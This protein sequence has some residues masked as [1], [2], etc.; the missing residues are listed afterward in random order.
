VYS[1]SETCGRPQ[2]LLYWYLDIYIHTHTHTHTHIHTHT[3]TADMYTHTRT[4]GKSM[5]LKV[6]VS[7]SQQV[8]KS[9]N[10]QLN[11]TLMAAISNMR[12]ITIDITCVYICVYIYIAYVY[13]CLYIYNKWQSSH[14]TLIHMLVGAHTTHT[15]IHRVVSAW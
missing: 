13:M 15:H 4:S 7:I 3:H 8:N 2:G 5:H 10:Q 6:F 12:K 14:N 11:H 9:T 1:V